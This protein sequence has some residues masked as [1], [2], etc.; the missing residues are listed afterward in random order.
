MQRLFFLFQPYLICLQLAFYFKVI[1]HVADPA[2]FCKSL[3]ALTIPDGAT[4]ISTINR[5]MRAYAT[6]IIGAEYILHWVLF[7]F[8]FYNLTS[9]LIICFTPL[10]Q[11]Y[12]TCFGTWSC[13]H[14]YLPLIKKK[15]FRIYFYIVQVIS[16]PQTAVGIALLNFDSA[17]LD[18][19][20]F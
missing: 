16:I 18:Q 12:M 17:K 10:G 13:F 9:L 7:L 11:L 5:S 15:R 3:A 4:V 14:I 19:S 1:E 2:E 8:S 20:R 6:A